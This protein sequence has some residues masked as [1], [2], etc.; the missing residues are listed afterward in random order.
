[1]HLYVDDV[2][3]LSG[4]AI[5]DGEAAH[6]VDYTRTEWAVGGRSDGAN[7]LNGCLAEVFLDINE[8]IDLSI[9]AN[10]RKFIDTNGK[11]VNLGVDGSIPF[12]SPPILYL[13]NEASTFHTNLGT[14]GDFSVTG[15]L[16]DCDTSPSD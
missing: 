2:E 11:P 13:A 5:F 4:G 14:G 15:A 12:G 8:Y 1:M 16:V 9:E 7:K 3:D 10:R 6:T